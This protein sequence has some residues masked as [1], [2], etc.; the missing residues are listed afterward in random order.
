MHG[1]RPLDLE[2]SV[3][4]GAWGVWALILAHQLHAVAV[5]WPRPVAGQ[6]VRPPEA[7]PEG[8]AGRPHAHWRFWALRRARSCPSSALRRPD[9]GAGRWPGMRRASL[10]N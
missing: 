10:A 8:R 1:G 3:R 5:A 6:P 9:V 2:G 4:C 7:A